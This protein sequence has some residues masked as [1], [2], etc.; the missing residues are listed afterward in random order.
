M[1]VAAH[2]SS[3]PYPVTLYVT[4]VR[5]KVDT[6]PFSTIKPS[7]PNPLFFIAVRIN[8]L[9]LSSVLSKINANS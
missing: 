4:L 1:K 9:T 8:T 3:V 5:S 2:N 7:S 6:P